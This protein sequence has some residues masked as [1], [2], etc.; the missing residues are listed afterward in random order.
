M[1]FTGYNEI[2]DNCIYR[3]TNT[4]LTTA[5]SLSGQHPT[6]A[7]GHLKKTFAENFHFWYLSK[8]F[9]NCFMSINGLSDVATLLQ[10]CSSPTQTTALPNSLRRFQMIGGS[11]P[12]DRFYLE[13]R[14]KMGSLHHFH[15]RSPPTS[16]EGAKMSLYQEGGFGSNFVWPRQWC[17]GVHHIEILWQWYIRKH[18][19]IYPK[20]ERYSRT[21][22]A[23]LKWS[24]CSLW[25]SSGGYMPL[26]L[27]LKY[28]NAYW[29]I[30]IDPV[31]QIVDTKN[32]MGVRSL[33]S[34]VLLSEILKL[35]CL[36]LRENL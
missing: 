36:D 13:R 20:L 30:L 29:V 1:V 21:I 10:F 18:E 2:H 6:T 3:G 16:S 5:W 15:F 31:P 34:D 9:R 8:K 17:D 32:L 27:I 25:W 26:Y 23:V 4:C 11:Y 28:T 35:H 14:V 19:N 22:F 24:S 33:V 7:T 12:Q